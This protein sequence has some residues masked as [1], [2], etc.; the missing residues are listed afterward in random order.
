M[1][2]TN[3][4]VEVDEQTLV[5]LQQI[6]TEM[7]QRIEG[8]EQ[9]KAQV[10]QYIQNFEGG[11]NGALTDFDKRKFAEQYAEQLGDIP[12]RV[13]SRY[14]EGEDFVSDLFN[15]AQGQDDKDAFVKQAIDAVKN[16]L[17]EA[18]KGLALVEETVEASEAG[19][20]AGAPGAPPPPP[21]AGGPL[22]LAATDQDLN[23]LTPD[24]IRELIGGV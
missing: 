22:E 23:G 4:F 14:G 5:Q 8:L 16:D 10:L 15:L 21:P 24:Q 3:T 2:K 6:L 1:I 11:L 7:A 12:T 17:L 19:P 13:A 20:G 18:A 9:A